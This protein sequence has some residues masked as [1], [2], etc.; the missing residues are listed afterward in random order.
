ME[1]YHMELSSDAK[2]TSLSSLTGLLIN[3]HS[4]SQS[5]SQSATHQEKQ[6]YKS[7]P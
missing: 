4:V 3:H 7:I 1:R 2:R 6:A 5:V